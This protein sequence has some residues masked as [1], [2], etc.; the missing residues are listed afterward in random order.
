MFDVKSVN[1]MVLWQLLIF[2]FRFWLTISTIFSHLFGPISADQLKTDIG[3]SCQMLP[4]ILIRFRL[5]PDAIF[6]I[7]KTLGPSTIPHTQCTYYGAH[8]TGPI[9]VIETIR[10]PKIWQFLYS[11]CTGQQNI[12]QILSISVWI[13]LPLQFWCIIIVSSRNWWHRGWRHCP[14]TEVW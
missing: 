7:T 10:E 4:D 8:I 1:F 2:I 12:A 13:C 11:L 5:Y 14:Y 3:R 6:L 9:S